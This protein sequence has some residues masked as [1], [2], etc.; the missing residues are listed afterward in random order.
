MDEYLR[1]DMNIDIEVDKIR[2][3]KNRQWQL[4][5]EIL[6]LGQANAKLGKKVE[7]LRKQQYLAKGRAWIE[8]DEDLDKKKKVKC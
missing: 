1:L 6:V 2:T 3:N 4:K 5:N 7:Q 8:L